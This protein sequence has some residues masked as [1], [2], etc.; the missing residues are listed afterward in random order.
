MSEMGQP[1]LLYI[2]GTPNKKDKMIKK[3]KKK[4]KKKKNVNNHRQLPIGKE[5]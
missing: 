2:R 5:F 4:K 3:K 1:K